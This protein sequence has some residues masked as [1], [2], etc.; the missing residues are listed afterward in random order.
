MDSFCLYPE[1]PKP[2]RRTHQHATGAMINE[3]LSLCNAFARAYCGFLGL[4][5]IQVAVSARRTPS[6]VLLSCPLGCQVPIVAWPASAICSRRCHAHVRVGMRVIS[7]RNHGHAGVFWHPSF[8][9]LHITYNKVAGAHPRR[10]SR[11]ICATCA[12]RTRW[13]I[14]RISSCVCITGCNN[15]A[16]RRVAEKAGSC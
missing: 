16:L 7:Y 14:C 5:R 13:G 15:S 1:R 9:L 10:G 4:P 2:R 3:R 11:Q 12:I 6:D 8:W